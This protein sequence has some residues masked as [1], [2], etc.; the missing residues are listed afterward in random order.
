MSCRAIRAASSGSAPVAAP[1]VAVTMGTS[2][3]LKEFTTG[4]MPS[5]SGTPPTACSTSDTAS[6][7]DR[8]LGPYTSLPTIIYNWARQPGDGFRALTAAAIVVLLVVVLLINAVAIILRN[9]YA[10]KW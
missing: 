7:F 10:R 1:I 6:F 2:M 9:R 8:L 4:L 3:M 5:G